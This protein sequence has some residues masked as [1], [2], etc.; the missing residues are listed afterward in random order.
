MAT[1][2]ILDK[3]IAELVAA[4]EVV[5]RPASVVKELVENAIDAGASSVSVAIEHGGVSCIQITDNGS[6]IDAECIPTAFARHATSKIATQDDLENIHTLGFRGEALASV[7]SVARVELL[8]CTKTDEFACLYRISGGEEE[9]LEAAARPVGTTVTV[10]DLFFNTPARMKFLKKD[11]SEANYVSE[12][13][14]HMALSRPDISFKFIREGKMQFQTAGDG[15]LRGAAYAV[16]SRDFSQELVDVKETMG[17]Y[18]VAGCVTPPKSGRAS[19]AMQFFFLNGRFIKNR[20]MMAALEAAYK[21]VLM[22]GKYPGCILSLTMP[23]DMVDVNVH[24]AKTEVRFA[25]EKDVFDLV[26]QAVKSVLLTPQ[27]TEKIF[28]FD[29]TAAAGANADEIQTA[30]AA[31]AAS[32]KSLEGTMPAAF[33]AP[34]HKRSFSPVTARPSDIYPEDVRP[35]PQRVKTNADMTESLAEE[36]VVPYGSSAASTTERAQSDEAMRLP[37]AA[38]VSAMETGAEDNA[39]KQ[40][41]LLDGTDEAQR[42]ALLFVGEVFDTY[43]I[44]QRG[45]DLCFIDKHA[46]HE[47][48][49]YEK[50]MK[51][52]GSVS[53]QMLLCPVTVQLSAEEKNAVLQNDALLAD[54]GV[55]LEDFGGNAVV[56]RAV[57]GDV[58]PDDVENLVIELADRMVHNPRDTTSEKTQWVLHSIA[59]RAAVKG[60][61]KTHAAQLLRLAEDVLDGC[62]PPFCPHGRPIVLK[63][64]KKELEKQFGRQ[65]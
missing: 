49:L 51:T 29:R 31:P 54:S 6:G 57:P 18:C 47:R 62:I 3:H 23:A 58:V 63:V 34:E 33:A 25:R 26:Y 65:G 41:T 10:R 42:A 55:E 40:L 36:S 19:R 64:T 28:L 11:T 60:G 15:N 46:A 43:I 38:E 35:M 7:A 59:C 44:T 37:P 32:E 22:Q 50:L 61:D 21:S 24:P 48:I 13:M 2:H 5:E 27:S 17:A 53:S 45:S 1:I 30:K 14:T 16:L 56:V 12:V 39:A 4:G 52:Y 9:C 8:T 20:T